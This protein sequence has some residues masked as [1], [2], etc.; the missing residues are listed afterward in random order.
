[1]KAIGNEDRGDERRRS[2]QAKLTDIFAE[3][4]LAMVLALLVCAGVMSA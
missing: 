3:R 1:V 2:G 4:W